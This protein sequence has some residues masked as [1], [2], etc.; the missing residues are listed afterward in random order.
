[1]GLPAVSLPEALPLNGLSPNALPA[2]F[3]CGCPAVSPPRAGLPLPKLAFGFG[4]PQTSSST[5][6]MS[7]GASADLPFGFQSRAG[8]SPEG[9]SRNGFSRR[10]RS[11]ASPSPDVLPF[12]GLSIRG[13]SRR[14]A[15]S[16]PPR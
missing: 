10:G 14:G 8:A 3:F 13:P 12:H 16:S 1:N 11:T 6:R 9:L 5:L 2:L 7:R 15:S 4:S